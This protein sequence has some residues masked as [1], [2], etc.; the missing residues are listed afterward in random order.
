MA[1]IVAWGVLLAWI[2]SQG[3][4]VQ[5]LHVTVHSKIGWGICFFG[6]I[7]VSRTFGP[8][9]RGPGGRAAI[10]VL[11]SIAS[12]ACLYVIWAHYRT[13]YQPFKIG[14]DHRFPHPDPAIVALLR[15]FQSRQPPLPPGTHRMHGAFPEVQFVLGILVL[16]SVCMT[17]FLLGL[18]W[19]RPEGEKPKPTE[20][21]YI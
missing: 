17:G 2:R 15:W 12:T 20:T 5:A 1:V 6:T 18:L 13:V 7:A 14:L 8:V 10:S 21:F 16:V 9:I 4:L 19:N 11:L 3:S